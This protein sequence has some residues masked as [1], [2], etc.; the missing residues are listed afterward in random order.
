MLRVTLLRGKRGN[1]LGIALVTR[2]VVLTRGVTAS[3]LA[4]R[5]TLHL[6][7]C[8]GVAFPVVFCHGHIEYVCEQ[9]LPIHTEPGECRFSSMEALRKLRLVP[10]GRQPS[11]RVC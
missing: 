3:G 4:A 11:E 10:F 6:C 8:C 5:D 1:L 7:D 2:D 9:C